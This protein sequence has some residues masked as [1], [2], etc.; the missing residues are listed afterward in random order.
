[1]KLTCETLENTLIF[2]SLAISEGLILETGGSSFGRRFIICILSMIF[3]NHLFTPPLDDI[4]VLSIGIR[5]R[6]HNLGLTAVRKD[7]NI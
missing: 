7:I 2:V 1:V 6:T 5:A 4:S 3:K